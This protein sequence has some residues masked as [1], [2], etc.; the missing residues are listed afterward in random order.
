MD[1]RSGFALVVGLVAAP[2]A[3]QNRARATVTPA[4]IERL[5]GAYRITFVSANQPADSPART[6]NGNL[7]LWRTDS[8]HR[9]FCGAAARDCAAHPEIATVM[10]LAGRTDATSSLNE[11]FTNDPR[12]RD[13]DV[14][15][16]QVTKQGD[17]IVGA[18]IGPTR[19]PT[20]DAGLR[21]NILRIDSASFY[22][23]WTSQ[24]LLIPRPTGWF[25]ATRVVAR[26]SMS[27]FD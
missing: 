26:D 16:V 7:S 14:P 6:A 8:T 15:G 5:A 4:A 27:D 1:V 19:G 2:C 3:P 18:S 22:G 25:C 13:P 11:V 17:M 24:S 20:A 12:A 9:T 23:V 10:L 21:M